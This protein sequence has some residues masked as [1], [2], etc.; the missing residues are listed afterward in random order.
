VL[1]EAGTL[2]AVEAGDDA[3]DEDVDE[4]RAFL[5]GVDPA[6]FGE[7]QDRDEPPDPND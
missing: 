5:D 7:P 2:L 6:D 4:F 3:I 1:D